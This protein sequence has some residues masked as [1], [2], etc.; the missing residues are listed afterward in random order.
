METRHL[1]DGVYASFDGYY[2]ELELL[3]QEPTLPITRI[4]LEPMVWKNLIDFVKEAEA[5]AEAVTKELMWW[6]YF[7]TSGDI[8][9]KRWFNDPLDIREAMESPFVKRVVA[10]FPADTREEA[11]AYMEKIR[12]S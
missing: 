5:E 7:H 6:G 3:A 10:A 4:M 1:G 11:I 8:Q 9:V 12:G 2:V